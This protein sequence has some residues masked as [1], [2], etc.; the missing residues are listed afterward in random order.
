MR[1]RVS[2]SVAGLSWFERKAAAALFSDPPKATYDEALN[3]FLAVYKLKPE[4]IENLVF[5]GKC[6]L[7]KNEKKE[8]IKYLKMAVEVFYLFSMG[9]Q[10]IGGSCFL[11]RIF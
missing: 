10:K 9:F 7:A 8:A 4:W 2:Y 3:D 11:F 5:L 1:G 6:Y